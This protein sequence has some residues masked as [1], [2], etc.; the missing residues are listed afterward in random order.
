MLQKRKFIMK[1]FNKGQNSSMNEKKSNL[2]R[3]VLLMLFVC[4][5]FSLTAQ[6]GN[7]N[8][9]LPPDIDEGKEYKIAVDGWYNNKS[10]S[11]KILEIED[12]WIQTFRKDGDHLWFPINKIVFIS[13]KGK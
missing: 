2:N 8:C 11:L 7:S 12:C 5:I 9:E 3:L 13:S 6:A 10:A 4:M 1:K